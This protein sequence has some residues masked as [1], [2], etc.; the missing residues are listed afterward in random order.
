[1]LYRYPPPIGNILEKINVFQ[2][3]ISWGADGGQVRQNGEGGGH[4]FTV[5]V[6]QGPDGATGARGAGAG[7]L[8][9][10]LRKL[11]DQ[12]AQ[13]QLQSSEHQRPPRDQT[14]NAF[15][16]LFTRS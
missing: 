6:R 15:I 9:A 3:S 10:E 13:T 11:P 14:M 16:G 1:M 12:N 2:N 7:Q 4:Q 8:G 5:T